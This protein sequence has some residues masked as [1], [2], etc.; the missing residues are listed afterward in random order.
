MPAFKPELTLAI[1][2]SD[3]KRSAGWYTNVLGFQ[4]V[5]A[6]EDMG[7][8][9]F[10]TPLAGANVGLSQSM[11]GEPVSQSGGATITLGVLDIAAARSELESKGVAFDGPTQDLP[12]LVRLATFRDPHGNALM[13]AQSLGEG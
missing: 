8:G 2:V 1:T 12:G 11:D 4:P 6:V 3:F 7:W 5:Y 10:S 9:E 13:L